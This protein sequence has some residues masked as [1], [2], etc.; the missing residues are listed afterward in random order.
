MYYL[1]E[2]RYDSLGNLTREYR[3][4][5]NIPTT[6]IAYAKQRME[7]LFQDKVI[8]FRHNVVGGSL[9]YGDRQCTMKLKTGCYEVA[10]LSTQD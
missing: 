5:G 2:R 3:V 6:E 10:I 4:S 1:V 9:S 7:H 8:A